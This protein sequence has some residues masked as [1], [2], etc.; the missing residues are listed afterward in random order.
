MTALVHPLTGQQILVAEKRAEEWRQAG[1]LDAETQNSA[2]V[3][4]AANKN[5]EGDHHDG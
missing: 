4:A 3:E 2:P 1:W 5:E